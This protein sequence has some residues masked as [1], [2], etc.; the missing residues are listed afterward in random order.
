MLSNPFY[1]AIGAYFTPRT[2]SNGTTFAI[3]IDRIA[4]LC[5]RVCK[6]VC[7][8]LS[9][10]FRSIY[11]AK[12]CAVQCDILSIYYI[13]IHL[14]CIYFIF[15]FVFVSAL[16]LNTWHVLLVYA[17]LLANPRAVSIQRWQYV[18]R[19]LSR[20]PL[21]ATVAI[22]LYKTYKIHI[23]LAVFGSFFSSFLFISFLFHF[24]EMH[25]WLVAFF[26]NAYF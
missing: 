25:M 1:Y 4:C 12:V 14:L 5:F 10:S 23:F 9:F 24:V 17:T 7:C 16:H 26:C 3:W 22:P 21:L 15:S 20:V 6:C 8:S 2:P 13:F 19:S 11:V 18:P